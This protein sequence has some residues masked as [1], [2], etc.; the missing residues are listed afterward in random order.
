ML[1]GILLAPAAALWLAGQAYPPGPQVLV[2]KS[3]VDGTEQ[4][5][6]VY[7]PRDFG[8]SRRYP[9]V[10][11]LH[12]EGSNHRL[13]LRRVFGR[14]NF[15]EVRRLGRGALI[16]ETDAEAG[17]GPFPPLP[18]VDFFVVSPLARGSM[19]YQGIPEK[20]VYDVLAE[21]KS[22]FPID[23]DRIYLT[24]AAM[25]GG[26]ALWLG[27]TRPDLWAA[28]AVAAPIPQ[29]G[30]EELASNALGLPVHLFQGALDPLVPAESARA[31]QSRLE[32]G[33]AKVRYTEYP[34][35]RHNVWDFAYREASIFRWFAPFK[36]DRF[37]ARVRFS[38]RS[39][40]YS[41]AYWVQLDGLTPGSL[42]AIDARFTAVNRIEV[43]TSS[44]DGF[45]LRVAGHPLYDASRPM[46]AVIDGEE[47]KGAVLSF[48]RTEKGWSAARLARSQSEKGPG[49]EGPI[50]QALARKHLYIYGTA[51]SPDEL[52][53]AR[54][55]AQAERAAHWASP[56][57][58]LLLS[59][60]ARSDQEVTEQE[61]EGADLVLFGNR[62]TNSLIERFGG[63]L[64]F[65]LSPSAAD[66][67]MVAIAPAGG[68]YILVSSGLPWWAGA[69]PPAKPGTPPP[70]SYKALLELGDYVVFRRS[71]ADVVAAGLFDRNWKLAPADA[72]K[73]A[74]SGVV[75]IR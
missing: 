2:F 71:L 23:E 32:Q 59:L 1:R 67:G 56:P 30:A 50:R 8:A 62:K 69:P 57:W 39:Y 61:L 41:S 27:L 53:L 31:W 28:I 51:D 29:P 5:Y 7:V 68:R 54:R 58:P 43:R 18:D 22:R 60:S 4:P 74:A 15:M 47:L 36:R 40:Q 12:S 48:S 55:R 10:V 35:V 37:P 75:Q 24:G 65:E 52:E 14:G 63:R 16:R 42:A 49:Q 44:L 6:A 45:T 3:D 11:S 17:N 26:G 70:P 33:G 46:V 13:D 20:D 34:H 38:T 73:L 21:V 19:G 64:A 9:L 25:G 66:Y 72:A